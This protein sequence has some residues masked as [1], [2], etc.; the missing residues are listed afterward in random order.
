MPHSAEPGKSYRGEWALFQDYCAAT[1]QRALP[2]TATIVERFFTAVPARPTTRDRRL[3]AIMAAHRNAGYHL[4]ELKEATQPAADRRSHLAAAGRMIAACP[5]AGWPTGFTGRRD[6]FL[7]VLIEVLRHTQREAGGLAP[8][9]ITL[10]PD[11]VSI[12]AAALPAS[13][14]PRGCPTCAT[15]RWLEVCDLVD[16]LGRAIARELL[17][18][19]PALAPTSAH[20][21]RPRHQRW[22]QMPYLVTGIDQHG[23]L[24]AQ[25]LSTRSINT[26]LAVARARADLPKS[27]R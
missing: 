13:D 17:S 18:V 27:R 6:G 9:A 5:T 22:R 25:P 15:V 8:A 3:H 26:R 16:G 11:G 4:E 24:S 12:G 1:D 20:S 14:D 7:I 23:W 19:V 10:T 2:T 21:H